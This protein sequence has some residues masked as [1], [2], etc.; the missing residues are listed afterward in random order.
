MECSGMSA[1]P[2]HHPLPLRSL[3]LSDT[4]ESRDTQGRPCSLGSNLPRRSGPW[5]RGHDSRCA[6]KCACRPEIRDS[7][8]VGP[9]ATGSRDRCSRRRCPE[10][11]RTTAFSSPGRTGL[12]DPLPSLQLSP[13]PTQ[14][15]ARA[16]ALAATQG[17]ANLPPGTPSPA[18]SPRIWIRPP[19]S[20]SSNEEAGLA[21]TP[22]L[23][24]S[25]VSGVELTQP[26]Q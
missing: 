13:L 21:H 12:T 2:Q 11:W 20:L 22:P 4:R 9:R 16:P 10:P 7:L 17:R 15:R 23:G 25:G 3:Q 24:P 5:R 19:H 14:T 1:V 8:T 18:L 26:G 6:A